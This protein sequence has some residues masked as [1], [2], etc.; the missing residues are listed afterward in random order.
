MRERTCCHSAHPRGNRHNDALLRLTTPAILIYM[1]KILEW[2]AAAGGLAVVVTTWHSVIT[3]IILPRSVTSE[4]TYRVWVFVQGLFRLATRMARTYES[5][6]RILALVGPIAL[7]SMLVAWMGL[8]LVGF[9]LLFLPFAPLRDAIMIAGS[10][11][12]TLGVSAAPRGFATFVEYIAAATGMIIIALQIGYLP[13]VYGAFNRRETLV[14][15]LRARSGTPTWGPEILAVHQRYN[16]VGTMGSMFAAWELWA[17]DITESHVSNPWLNVFRSPV[18]QHSWVLG[19]LAVLDSAAIY[20]AVAPD[21]APPEARPCLRAGMIAFRTL[22]RQAGPPRRFDRPPEQVELDTPV[23]ITLDQFIEAVDHIAAVG[24]P[25]TETSG[26]AW[27]VFQF[28]RS[29][30]EDAA[31]VLADFVAAPYV[32]WSR[33]EYIPMRPGHVWPSQIAR[34]VPMRTPPPRPPDE[35]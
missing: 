15:S 10:S 24:F 7:L 12:F 33:R 5:K 28:W 8:F 31:Y 11:F 9:T 16:M 29:Q 14:L 20:V 4:I 26:D 27:K 32:P 18:A 1:I 17:A 35:A 34:T 30:Y 23:N 21:Q 6:D 25:V 13:T 2:L 22:A 19:L 3:T